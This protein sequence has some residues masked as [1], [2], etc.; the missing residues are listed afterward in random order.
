MNMPLTSYDL[1]G[2][3]KKPS[4]NNDVG[5][6]KKCTLSVEGMTCS[7]CVAT[8]EKQIG[9]VPGGCQIVLCI[10]SN[11]IFYNALNNKLITN[12]QYSLC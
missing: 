10:Y 12:L 11:L 9:A 5:S 8:I 3:E 2:S 4:E 7:S 6:L 1:L